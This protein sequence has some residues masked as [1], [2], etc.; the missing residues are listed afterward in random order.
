MEKVNLNGLMED[1]MMDN[2][3]LENK[4]EEVLILDKMARKKRVNG[5][6]EKEQNGSNR[7]DEKL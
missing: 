3:D 2:G 7:T 4:M 5:K 1:N 6:K